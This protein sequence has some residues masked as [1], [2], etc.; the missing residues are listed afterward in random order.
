MNRIIVI[1]NGFD[2]AHNLKTGYRDFINYYWDHVMIKIYTPHDQ[3]LQ[4]HWPGIPYLRDY[5]DEFVFFERESDKTKVNKHFFTYQKDSSFGKLYELI[6]EHNNCSPVTG[7][8]KFKNAFLKRIT[9]QCSLTN[10][11]DIENEYYDALKKLLLEEDANKRS[12]Q[13]SILNNEFDAVKKLLE[14]YL[15]NYSG[16]FS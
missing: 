16:I 10:W 6:D 13:I 4:E 8:L 12:S 1:G 15:S 5:E 3:L 9:T 11:V 7:Y 14:E 2:M